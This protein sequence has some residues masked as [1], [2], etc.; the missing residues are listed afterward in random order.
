MKTLITVLT[1]TLGLAT[2]FPPLQQALA[3]D[4]SVAGITFNNAWARASTGGGRPSAAYVTI[5]NTGAPDVL[6]GGSSPVAKKVEIH[7]SKMENG[8]MKM[9]KVE[10]L[11]LPKGHEVVMKPGGYHVMMMGLKQPLKM[12]DTV[13]LTLHLKNAGDVTIHVPVKH[14]AAPHGL[15]ATMKHK[16]H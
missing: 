4:A 16:K 3:S 8:I 13:T 5:K 11:A 14:A 10:P 15:G 12:G 6:T 2:G 9:N 7:Q 1:L